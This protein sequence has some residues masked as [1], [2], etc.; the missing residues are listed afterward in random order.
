MVPR[1]GT[2]RSSNSGR[3]C[4]VYPLVARMMWRAFIVPRG[5]CRICLGPASRPLAFSVHGSIFVTGVFVCRFKRPSLI[6]FSRMKA[7]SLYG[8]RLPAPAVSVAPAAPFTRCFRSSI[9]SSITV[10]CLPIS[11]ASRFKSLTSSAAALVNGF[12]QKV[13]QPVTERHSHGTSFS[14]M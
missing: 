1:S 2:M 14:L 7:M 5:V 13:L 3:R 11:G 8:Q 4:D 12:V 10:T 6:S 9:S